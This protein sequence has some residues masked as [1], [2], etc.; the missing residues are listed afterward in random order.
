MNGRYFWLQGLGFVF[1]FFSL[2]G[3]VDEDGMESYR[4]R[5]VVEGWIEEGN[6]AYVI[7]SQNNPLISTVDS[8]SIENMVIRWAKVTV[9]D[10]EKSEILRGRI[11]GNYFPPFIYHGTEL[12]GQAG[13]TYTLTVEYS[14]HVWTAE[15]TI[16]ESLPLTS[17]RAE[18]VE[19]RDTLYSLKATFRDPEGEKNY[20]KFFTRIMD[21]K[22]RF[23]PSLMGNFDD[24]LFDGKEMEVT[25]N[26]GIQMKELKKFSAY[27]HERDTVIVK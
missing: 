14:G 17:L 2:F 16:P 21:K 12:M 6:V 26:Q 20:Y 18:P 5:L 15:T 9:S 1:L 25:V 4:Y 19:G 10:G 11:D 27:F 24:N 3:C 8:T 7:L 13:K 23:L 22:G